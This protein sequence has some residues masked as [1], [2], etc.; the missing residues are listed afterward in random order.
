MIIRNDFHNTEVR[1]RSTLGD[2]LSTSQIARAKRALCGI[3]GCRCSGDAGERG[4]QEGFELLPATQDT[5]RVVP[6][7]YSPPTPDEARALLKRWGLTGSAAGAL[8]G[9]VDGRQ[10]RR[11]TGGASRLPFAALYTLAARCEGVDLTPERW[12]TEM[13]I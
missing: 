9:G 13:K 1:I 8:L 3:D 6:T 2:E 7:T 12:R 5:L 11:W 4:P 10:I